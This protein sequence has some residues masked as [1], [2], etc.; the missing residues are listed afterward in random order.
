MSICVALR[1]KSGAYHEDEQA[2]STLSELADSSDLDGELVARGVR[3]LGSFFFHDAELLEEM[4]EYAP[5]NAIESLRSLQ[6]AARN[7]P[8]WHQPED[9]LKSIAALIDLLQRRDSHP[10]AVADLESFHRVLTRAAVT[11]DQFRFEAG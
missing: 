10:V 11:G 8:A 5:A 9:G 1:L 3:P 4:L 2:S 7:Q 6:D